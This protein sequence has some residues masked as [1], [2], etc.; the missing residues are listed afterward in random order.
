MEDNGV[1][2]SS[3]ESN[4]V[5]AAQDPT[6]NLKAE[7]NRKLSKLD[8]KLNTLLS[9]VGNKGQNSPVEET[10]SEPTDSKRIK[11]EIK[12][13]NAK[14]VHH[15]QFQ[16]AKKLFPEL[17]DESDAFDA[18]FYKD[19]DRTYEKLLKA[20]PT[21]KDALK[22]AIELVANRTG[23][24]KRIVK[25][26]FLKDEAR[27]SRIISE[28]ASTSRESKREKDPQ[29]NESMAKRLGVD[30]AKLAARIKANKDK[31]GAK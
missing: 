1:T 16:E 13:E 12:A 15:Q 11:Q 7:F 20:D 23:K 9:A 28:G 25:D 3:P 19:V 2:D 8:E 18:T 22:D 6:K 21:D 24:N 26:E 10:D 4:A 27:R 17:D 14:E 5:T 29:I 30:P 31:Y